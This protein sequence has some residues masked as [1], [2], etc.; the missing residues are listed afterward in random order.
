MWY[1]IGLGFAGL[2]GLLLWADGAGF[3]RPKRKS[4]SGARGG[5]YLIRTKKPS[6]PLGMSLKWMLA[7][8]LLL[9]LAAYI[10]GSAWWWVALALPLFSGRHNGYV[11]LTSSYYHRQRQHL[12]GGG[13]YK[14]QRKDWADLDP[15]FYKILPLPNWR[16]LLHT[17]ET[18]LI[19]LLC[20]VYNVQKQP[21]WNLRKVSPRT[22]ERQAW[23]RAKYGHWSAIGRMIG[24]GFLVLFCAVLVVSLLIYATES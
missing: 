23:E 18:L 22:A 7:G 21:P 20:P 4:R 2:L 11:G 5:I 10:V 15:K 14:A 6:A 24:R 9:A 12:I 16:W 17:M 19:A 13:V 3:S 8:A 1:A